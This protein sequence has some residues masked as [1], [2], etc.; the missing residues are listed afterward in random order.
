MLEDVDVL[1]PYCGETFS[2]QVDCSPGDHAFIEDCQ[3]CC[4]PIH[5]TLTVD[6][7]G[8]VQSLEARR[9]ND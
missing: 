4:S 6:G 9:D 7:R 3:I 2:L 5:F 8:G 1:C